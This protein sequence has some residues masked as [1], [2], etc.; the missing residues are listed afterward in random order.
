MWLLISN[1][2]I[3]KEELENVKACYIGGTIYFSDD[4][5]IQIALHEFLHS[6]QNE[7][8]D[9]VN[10]AIKEGGSLSLFPH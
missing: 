1:Y 10:L 3:A 9:H 5:C 7:K 2:K 4:V 6:I 8:W